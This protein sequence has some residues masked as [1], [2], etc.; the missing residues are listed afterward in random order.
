MQ[1]EKI[2]SIEAALT[3][4][5]Y[6]SAKALFGEYAASIGIDLA[7]QKFDDELL[8]INLVYGPPNGVL[9]LVSAGEQ[10]IGCAGI[11]KFDVTTA[12]LKRMYIQPAFRRLKLGAALL[13]K[14]LDVAAAL[15]YQYIRLDTLQEMQAAIQLYKA[16]GF[17]EI[18]PYRFNPLAGAVFMEKKLG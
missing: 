5:D 11:R 4:A 7:F 8:Q 10:P 1:A 15:G 14:C 3:E 6:Q 17:Y 18:A 12:E 13:E 9:L 16:A 2:I